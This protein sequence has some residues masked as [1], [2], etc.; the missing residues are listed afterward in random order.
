MG[1]VWLIARYVHMCTAQH[2][3]TH[4]SLS[5][6]PR[7]KILSRRDP[8]DCVTCFHESSLR[9]SLP[10]L[11]PPPSPMAHDRIT[12]LTDQLTL[13]PSLVYCTLVPLLF[14]ECVK[15]EIYL[16]H[17]FCYPFP[18]FPR[19]NSVQNLPNGL[20]SVARRRLTKTSQKAMNCARALSD[21]SLMDII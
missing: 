2:A 15:I 3:H 10:P 4:L 20:V 13:L 1:Q 21:F 6:K 19:P 7:Q 8:Y 11:P 12:A 5:K 18:L 9:F 14:V 17:A 16:C